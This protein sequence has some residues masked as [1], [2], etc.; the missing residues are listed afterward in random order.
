MKWSPSEAGLLVSL[1]AQFPH[2]TWEH[3]T[4]IFNTHVPRERQ[5]I[6]NG[7]TDFI[8]AHGF[9]M[10]FKPQTVTMTGVCR[11]GSWH[12][13]R[14]MRPRSLTCLQCYILLCGNSR[15]CVY[16]KIFSHFVFESKSIHPGQESYLRE[17]SSDSRNILYPDSLADCRIAIS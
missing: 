10:Y 12:L 9:G 14:F 16:S 11:E 1:R 15:S 7:H 3:L 4:S 2:D 17:C 6:A 5:N 13:A 8:C